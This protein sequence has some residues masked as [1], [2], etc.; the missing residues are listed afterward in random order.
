M[1]LRSANE[2]AQLD[3]E[4]GSK[5]FLGSQATFQQKSTD[6]SS[7]KDARVEAIFVFV[8]LVSQSGLLFI[9]HIMA[10]SKVKAMGLAKFGRKEL[11]FAERNAKTHG[12][13]RGVWSCPAVQG[14]GTDLCT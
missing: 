3:Q 1:R 11:S 8:S 9:V 5:N 13:S 2:R 7:T 6:A 14:F 12:V 10:E 4:L